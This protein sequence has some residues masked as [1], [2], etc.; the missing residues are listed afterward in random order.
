M[1]IRKGFNLPFCPL[2]L[3]RK[4]HVF[5]DK[6]KF[7]IIIIVATPFTPASPIYNIIRFILIGY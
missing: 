4:D 3:S 1:S 2:Y 6:L 7:N 5:N